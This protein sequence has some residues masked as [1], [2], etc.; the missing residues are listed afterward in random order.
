MATPDPDA[1][2]VLIADDAADIRLLLRMYL[3][4]SKLEVIGEAANGKEAVNL[5]TTHKPDA[6]ILD[7]SMPVMDGL[8][9]IPLIKEAS[10]D[11]KIVV[12]SGF[13]ADRMAEAALELGA[14]RYLQKG[15]SLGDISQMLW[16][17]CRPSP[18]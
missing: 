7:L 14:D 12:L 18:E 2:R 10:P 1:L 6:V 3:S 9:A 4:G 16:D 13:E 8:E 15:V 11:T 5:V 17:L